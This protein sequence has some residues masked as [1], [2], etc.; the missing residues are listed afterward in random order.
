MT[1]SI[2]IFKSSVYLLYKNPILFVLPSIGSIISIIF[3]AF[4]LVELR[5][6]KNNQNYFP[7]PDIFILFLF[8]ISFTIAYFQLILISRKI[9][10][11]RGFENKNYCYNIIIFEL[12]VIYSFY[13]LTL[14]DIGGYETE[15]RGKLA[16]TTTDHFSMYTSKIS[17][18]YDNLFA[19]I[20][21]FGIPL[22]FLVS[23]ISM[24]FNAWMVEYILQIP[25]DET[26]RRSL[27]SGILGPYQSLK[28]IAILTIYGMDKDTK[29]AIA[30]LFILSTLISITGFVFADIA[31]IP[32]ADSLS[33]YI[34]QFAI[35]N[36]IEAIY[37][38]FFLVCLFLMFLSRPFNIDD[39][40]ILHF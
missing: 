16:S 12:L 40:N 26:K 35:L 3:E 36:I 5:N 20:V 21:S 37:L 38:P 22:V 1:D 29:K 9:I 34:S 32:A 19:T 31:V 28:N 2:N 13:A 8:F 25:A 24:F 17:I 18:H 23:I 15:M 27:R 6:N 11:K 33:L 39:D 14:V 4:Y 7:F 30:L 10:P